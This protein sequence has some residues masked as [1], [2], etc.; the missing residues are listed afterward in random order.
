M[1]LID[2]CVS[3]ARGFGSVVKHSTADPGIAT[4]IPLTPTKIIKRIYVLV[5][6]RKNAPVYQCFTLGTLNM[7]CVVGAPVSCTMGH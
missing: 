2:S 1:I 6:S 4:S 3:V 5:L 7:V